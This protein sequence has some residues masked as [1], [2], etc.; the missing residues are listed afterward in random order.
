MHTQ[1]VAQRQRLA[2]SCPGANGS[3]S[4]SD[5][6]AGTGS[7]VAA[8]SRSGDLTVLLCPLPGQASGICIDTAPPGGD[9][10]SVAAA[11]AAAVA[12]IIH[13][14]IYSLYIEFHLHRKY[15]V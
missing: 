4:E 9:G 10:G 5:L 7:A 3:G 2:H 13:T 15:S 11:A 14:H 6:D 1:S 8:D 12:H